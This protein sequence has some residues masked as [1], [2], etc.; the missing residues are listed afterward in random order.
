[1]LAD[2]KAGKITE[3]TINDN[4]GRILRVILLSGIMDNPHAASGEV[5]TPAQQ[6]VVREGETE[7]IVLLK[8]QNNLL[9]LDPSKIHSIAV[10]GP[11]ALVART[12][13][14]GSSLVRPKYA[15]SPLQG[16]QKRAGV[17]IDITSALGVGME[18]ED[19]AH[20]TPEASRERFESSDRCR[21]ES[22]RCR[23]S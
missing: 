8:N 1:M 20:D 12:G 6:Q 2:V 4:V 21:R 9:P 23:S 19:P 17:G 15:I 7:G 13:G 3:A 5:D 18:G 10:I 16:I 14:G 22:R 11:N